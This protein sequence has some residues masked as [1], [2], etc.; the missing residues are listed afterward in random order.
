[1][2]TCTLIKLIPQENAVQCAAIANDVLFC[3]T[4]G[5]WVVAM[6]IDKNNEFTVV[7]QEKFGPVWV[8]CMAVYLNRTLVLGGGDYSIQFMHGKGKVN[9]KV[10]QPTGKLILQWSPEDVSQWVEAQ[11]FCEHCEA[12]QINGVDGNVLFELTGKF[13]LSFFIF[14]ALLKK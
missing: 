10:A 14:S 6:K 7:H 12:F 3:G 13:A 11:G 8:N 5:G 2:K 1:M 9:Y 4:K